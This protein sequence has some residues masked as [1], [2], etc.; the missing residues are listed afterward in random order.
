MKCMWSMQRHVSSTTDRCFLA[1]ICFVDHTGK[2]ISS[3]QS[4]TG[5]VNSDRYD[6]QYRASSERDVCTGPK[7]DAL[8]KTTSLNATSKAISRSHTLYSKD[9]GILLTFLSFLSTSNKVP[10][11]LLIRGATARKRWSAEGS[12]EEKE[13]NHNDLSRELCTLL[14]DPTRLQS[15]LNKL[16]SSSAVLD[17]GDGTY[18]VNESIANDIAEN[19]SAEVISFWRCQALVVVCRAISWK[20]IETA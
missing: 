19:V 13:A 12:I 8:W 10:L 3:S 2:V 15:S 4:A 6:M 7:A 16:A 5:L 11:D 9:T 1:D 20:Y 17:N 14:L 18:T